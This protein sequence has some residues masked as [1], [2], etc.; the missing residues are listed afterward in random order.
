MLIV[1]NELFGRNMIK[2]FNFFK[3][4][5]LICGYVLLSERVF[6]NMCMGKKLFK[7][8]GIL[9]LLLEYFDIINWCICLKYSGK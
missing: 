8:F 4:I 7:L 5:I 2:F 6:I 9:Y 3:W 1:V